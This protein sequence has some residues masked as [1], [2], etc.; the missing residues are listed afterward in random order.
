M[1]SKEYIAAFGRLTQSQDNK[2]VVVPTEV[3]ALA[4]LA[5]SFLSSL[6]L[7]DRVQE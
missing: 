2:L 4:G 6:K 1:L 5:T 7:D 3:S